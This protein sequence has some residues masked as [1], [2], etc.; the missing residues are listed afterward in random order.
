MSNLTFPKLSLWSTSVPPSSMPKRGLPLFPLLNKWHQ[1]S[2]DVEMCVY[3]HTYTHTYIYIHT[4]L[5]DGLLGLDSGMPFLLPY[6]CK[7]HDCYIPRHGP[8]FSKSKVFSMFLLNKRKKKEEFFVWI[9]S[10]F[11]PGNFPWYSL[12]FSVIF[13]RIFFQ[14]SLSGNFSLPKVLFPG[15]CIAVY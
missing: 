11:T 13:L 3:T 8:K 4:S 15:I 12:I 2:W 9:S 10:L 14:T 6:C 1:E 5:R 7:D